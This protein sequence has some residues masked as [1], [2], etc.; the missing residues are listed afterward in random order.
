MPSD[1][2]AFLGFVSNE[3]DAVSAALQIRFE[4]NVLLGPKQR[5]SKIQTLLREAHI[6]AIDRAGFTLDEKTRE[7]GNLIASTPCGR[8][9]F[10]PFSLEMVYEPVELGHLPGDAMLGVAISGRYF[11][12]FLDYKEPYGGGAYIDCSDPLIQLAKDQIT[13]KLPIFSSS[14]LLVV[15]VV[16]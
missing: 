13:L 5:L 11:P 3:L 10:K 7:E 4:E 9:E 16:Y 8:R 6:L 1:Y 12:V 14:R 2:H 15:G